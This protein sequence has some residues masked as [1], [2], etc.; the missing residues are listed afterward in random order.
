M[1]NFLKR[2]FG[3]A[4]PAS[5]PTGNRVGMDAEHVQFRRAVERCDSLKFAVEAGQMSIGDV[6]EKLL[7]NNFPRPI[8]RRAIAECFGES[9]AKKYC[10]GTRA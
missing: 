2:L 7:S 9:A 3:G 4:A 10:G 1:G 8:V 6:V 5:T